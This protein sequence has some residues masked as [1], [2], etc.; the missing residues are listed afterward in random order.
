MV[1]TI[2]IGS[3]HGGYELKKAIKSALEKKGYKIADVGSHSEKPCDYPELGFEAARQ[4]ALKKAWRGIVI[5]K[6]GI[7]MAMVANKLPGVRAGL[8]LSVE[9]AASA[10]KH[11]DANV[12]VLGA[13]KTRP[14]KALN[15]VETWLKTEALKGRH[16]RRVRQIRAFEKKVFKKTI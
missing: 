2:V 16:A 9:D 4:V 1:K 8:C 6:S 12:L 3:D 7:G 13:K 15:I 14:K 10:R 5:C 11:N